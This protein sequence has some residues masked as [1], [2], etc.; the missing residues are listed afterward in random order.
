MQR[1][2]RGTSA[3]GKPHR[4]MAVWTATH[5]NGW[6]THVVENPDGSFAAWAAPA[7][8]DRTVAVAALA[9]QA[10]RSAAATLLEHTGHDACSPSCSRWLL[11]TYAV[12][13]RAALASAR[14]AEKDHRRD[15]PA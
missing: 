2:R 10:K 9:E 12:F 11:R 7:G 6:Q 13:D 15:A 4:M 8:E 1:Q 5:D 14:S 3:Y